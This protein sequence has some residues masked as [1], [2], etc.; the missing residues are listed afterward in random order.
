MYWSR[1][2]IVQELALARRVIICCGQLRVAG[3]VL[4]ACLEYCLGFSDGE[5]DRMATGMNLSLIIAQSHLRSSGKM[6]K[7]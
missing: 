4:P 6:C 3:F 1:L 7:P 2:W 5:L